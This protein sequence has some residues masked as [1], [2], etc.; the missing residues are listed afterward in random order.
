M[1]GFK[2]RTYRNVLEFLHDVGFLLKNRK[3]IRAI[4]ESESLPPAFRERMMLAVTHVNECRYCAHFHTKAALD[5][6]ISREEVDAILHGAFKDCPSDQLTGVLYAEHW[7]ETMGAPDAEI[8]AKLATAYGQETADNIDVVLRMIKTG[9]FTGNTA[10]YLLYRISFG[11][12][13]L[14]RQRD[15]AQPQ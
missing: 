3:R 8:R 7:A 15:R 2:K 5:E 10:D 12:W 1:D 11:K 4:L 13:G 14:P 6:G 9:N